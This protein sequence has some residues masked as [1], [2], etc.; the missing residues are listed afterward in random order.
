V[1]VLRPVGDDHVLVEASAR[2]RLELGAGG[3]TSA[4]VD[5]ADGFPSRVAL[6]REDGIV[7]IDV[8]GTLTDGAALH[9]RV[10][11]PPD[12]GGADPAV[13][14][15]RAAELLRG[16]RL[17][18]RRPSSLTPAATPSAVESVATP[19]PTPE[20]RLIRLG[21]GMGT[22]TAR[23]IGAA[24]SLG[25]TVSASVPIMR[26]VSFVAGA[27]GPFFTDRPAT[28]VGSAHTR[29]ELGFLGLRIET[30]R[31]R[32][33]AHAFFGAALHHLRASYDLRGVPAEP[34]PAPFHLLTPQ[35]VWT[36][37]VTLAAG[38]S[39]RLSRRGGVSLEVAAIVAQPATELIANERSLG[40]IG[41]PSFLQTLSAWIEFR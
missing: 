1:A 2:I 39:V 38:G 33:N 20:V 6:V 12:E 14:A 28:P 10:R 29:E 17:E 36:P 22:L 15:V 32:V 37:V 27:A 19:V 16:I 13:I 11:V 8:L 41:G 26:H 5:A 9:R 23:P 31:P 34:P 35:S 4:L 40:T 18:V 24:L 21:A 7:T 30:R 3:L 25:P